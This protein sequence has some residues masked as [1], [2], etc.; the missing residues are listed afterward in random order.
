MAGARIV[1]VTGA[2]RGIGRAMAEAFSATG[3][4]VVG[5]DIE[6]LGRRRRAEQAAILGRRRG[7]QKPCNSPGKGRLA[8]TA[9]PCQQPTVMQ[10]V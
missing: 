3:D 8:D 10:T 5:I 1:V 6:R 7:Q 9:W 2:A 4:R